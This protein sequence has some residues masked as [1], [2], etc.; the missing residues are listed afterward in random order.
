[1]LLDILLYFIGVSKGIKLSHLTKVFHSLSGVID[2]NLETR[3]IGE[4]TD[5]LKE[6]LKTVC[7]EQRIVV[8]NTSTSS[9]LPEQ[10][11]PNSKASSSENEAHQYISYLE[12]HCP[13]VVGPGQVYV[14]YDPEGLFYNTLETLKQHF[15]SNPD[16]FVC[17]D[18]ITHR[19][20]TMG[21]GTGAVF[22]I[23]Q[24][25]A[26]IKQIGHVVLVMSPWNNLRI[27]RRTAM[28][29]EIHCAVTNDCKFEIALSDYD[30]KELS[31]AVVN[32]VVDEMMEGLEW[33]NFEKS[34]SRFHSLNELVKV[35]VK[36]FDIAN[37][38]V[39]NA[40][41]D[42]LIAQSQSKGLPFFAIFPIHLIF[43]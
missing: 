31:K 14:S 19:R 17:L 21:D 30:R 22:L 4:F 36:P 23:D 25:E 16:V 43:F 6:K 28:L 2:P 13:S 18:N 37:L 27:F 15:E 11:E 40:V 41:R 9:L 5:A 33:I 3:N 1:M 38:V 8:A 20:P 34:V 7:N 39:S 32:G 24:F 12:E 29:F 42:C 35:A 26:T 10:S